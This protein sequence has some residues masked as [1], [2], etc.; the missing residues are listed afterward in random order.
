MRGNLTY[1]GS[2]F[3]FKSTNLKIDDSKVTVPEG[4][5]K[6]EAEESM[7]LTACY[8]KAKGIAVSADVVQDTTNEYVAGL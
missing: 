2:Y 8:V 5:L 1:S 4:I 6:L 7:R 3:S